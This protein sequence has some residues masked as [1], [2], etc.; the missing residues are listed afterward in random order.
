MA[1]IAAKASKRPA[2]ARQATPKPWRV[3]FDTDNRLFGPGAMFKAKQAGRKINSVSVFIADFQGA[4][5][6]PR[7]ALHFSSCLQNRAL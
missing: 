5:Q 4:A 7:G 6:R 3:A 2:P 1:I